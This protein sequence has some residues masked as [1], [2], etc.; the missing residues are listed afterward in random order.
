[1]QKLREKTYNLLRK[2]EKYFK[3]DMVYLVKGGSWLTLNRVIGSIIA[4]T[5]AVV[6][7]NLLPK[8]SYG[9]YKY[10]LSIVSILAITT[11]PGMDIALTRSIVNGYEGS[12]KKVIKT[13]LAWS[14]LGIITGLGISVYYFTMGILYLE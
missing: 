11:L 5:L 13:K 14:L 6:Y 1:M 3:T 7:A 10:V 8:E 4:L 9:L 2:S 12:I